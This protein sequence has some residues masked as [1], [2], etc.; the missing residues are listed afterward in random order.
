M[1]NVVFSKDNVSIQQCL[2][3]IADSLD[4]GEYEADSAT[5]VLGTGVF[6]MGTIKNEVAVRDAV[7][8][9]NYA[10]HKLMAPCFEDEG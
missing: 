2:R 3:N 5:L 8:N 7:W 9:L 10:I 4:E 1:N 6:H